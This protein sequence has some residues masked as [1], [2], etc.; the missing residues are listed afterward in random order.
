MPR[1]GMPD[2]PVDQVAP[3]PVLVAAG[4]VVGRDD[5]AVLLQQRTDDGTWGPPG[6][7][8]HPGETLEQTARR[9]LFEETGLTVGTLALLDVY[10]G[11]DLVVRY[12]DGNAAYVV[13]ATY[14][15]V[16]VTGVPTVDGVESTA[17]AWFR[18]D[19]LPAQVNAFNRTVLARVGLVCPDR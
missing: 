18:P 5:G 14:G 11:P 7:G 3:L 15:A 6:G 9:E 17:L 2:V 1:S 19:D 8:L 10:S 16:E 4:V 12:P 13:G